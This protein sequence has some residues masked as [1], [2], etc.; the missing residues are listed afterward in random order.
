MTSEEEELFSDTSGP[1]SPL[2]FSETRGSLHSLAVRRGSRGSTTYTTTPSSRGSSANLLD[3][4]W[5]S[6]SEDLN[7][8]EFFDQPL[9]PPNPP[10]IALPRAPRVFAFPPRNRYN[11]KFR[12][13]PYPDSDSDEDLGLEKLFEVVAPLPAPPLPPVPLA[14]RRRRLEDDNMSAGV[15]NLASPPNFYFYHILYFRIFIIS[16]Y[17]YIFILV[18]FPYIDIYWQSRVRV[19]A[20]LE[21]I[22]QITFDEK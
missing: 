2:A 13:P 1:P 14:A 11:F 22:V 4:N 8:D 17:F 15:E 7:L 16:L 6:E 12:F 3:L 19:A 21:L 18:I 10:H 5:D 20:R 9:L